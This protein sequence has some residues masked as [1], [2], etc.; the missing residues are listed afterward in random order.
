MRF[1]LNAKLFV[2]HTNHLQA[3]RD[4]EA[5]FPKRRTSSNDI[6]RISSAPARC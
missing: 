2:P 1:Y 5:G 6:S 4:A 3:A